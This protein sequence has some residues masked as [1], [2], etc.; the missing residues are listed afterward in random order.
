M[1]HATT[2]SLP[3]G[4]PPAPGQPAVRKA[5]Q[6]D[7]PGIAET[8]ARA[9]KDD[10]IQQYLFDGR[11]DQPELTRSF[12]KLGLRELAM[13][14]DEVYLAGECDGAALW[15][16]PGKGKTSLLEGL[17]LA[18]AI[19]RVAGISAIPRILRAFNALEAK[20]P[21]QDHFYLMAL[22]V[23]PEMQ[24]RG[25]GS[26]LMRPMLERCDREG[27]PAYLESSSPRNV[28]LYERHGFR[29]T[30]S[31]QLSRGGPEVWFMWREPHQ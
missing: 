31:M 22:A 17:R 23:R 2:R 3:T 21:E 8:L 13:P 24:G 5:T 26:A 20:H 25:I 19:I 16:P 9:F 12:M 6:A 14:H 28:P 15:L 11:D 30:E 7:I 27:L 10:P 1:A 4:A 29:V 18:P